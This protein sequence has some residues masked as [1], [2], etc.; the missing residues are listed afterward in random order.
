[1]AINR[2]FVLAAIPFVIGGF[3]LAVSKQAVADQ[4]SLL[5]QDSAQPNVQ[6]KGRGNK[7]A[8]LGLSAEQQTKIQQIKQSSRQQMDSVLTAEQK[9]LLQTAK[10]QRQRPNLNLT[11]DQKARMKAIKESS[12]TQIDAVLTAEQKQ[13]LQ[14]LKQQ[15]QQ[16]RQNRQSRQQVQS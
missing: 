9:Q 15:W 3:S 1:M 5:A 10:Q 11:E 16:N 6:R 4:P 8:Q 7:F 2:L 14:E 13:K 12:K